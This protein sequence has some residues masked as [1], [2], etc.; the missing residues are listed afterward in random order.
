M[1]FRPARNPACRTPFTW[2]TGV[3]LVASWK[4]NLA[5]DAETGERPRPE[6]LEQKATTNRLER[7]KLAAEIAKLNQ[8]ITRLRSENSAWGTI[9]R[10]AWPVASGVLT[11]VIS[12][13]A[14]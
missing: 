12:I 4:Y 13:I 11:V 1:Y 10:N 3:H 7:A 5:M 2:T 9:S 6:A 14:L 8:E